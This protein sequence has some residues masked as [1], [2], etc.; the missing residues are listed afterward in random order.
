M[1]RVFQ[2][3]YFNL[4]LSYN[5]LLWENLL[6]FPVLRNKEMALE[7]LKSMQFFLLSI[8]FK[9]FYFL[10]FIIFYYFLDNKS[11]FLFLLLFLF[12]LFFIFTIVKHNVLNLLWI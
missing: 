2:V 5:A 12:F 10:F 3:Q 4:N 9:I 1:V 11:I 8:Y 7:F 6:F